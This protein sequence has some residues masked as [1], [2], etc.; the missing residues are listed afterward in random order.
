MVGALSVNSAGAMLA[1]SSATITPLIL[2]RCTGWVG[3][4]EVMM[5]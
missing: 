1:A 2:I 3:S 5:T 4:L